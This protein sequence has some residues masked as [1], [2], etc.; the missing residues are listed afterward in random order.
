VLIKSVA[1]SKSQNSDL[2]VSNARWGI[3]PRPDRPESREKVDEVERITEPISHDLTL[4]Q[5]APLLVEM[6]HSRRDPPVNCLEKPW[7]RR[8]PPCLTVDLD[9]LK[10]GEARRLRW[11][12]LET[13]FFE[14]LNLRR[15]RLRHRVAGASNGDLFA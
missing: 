5:C 11:T 1:A 3:E 12:L 10:K 8:L 14:L 15:E 13:S 6:K 9:N 7:R 4:D 2:R